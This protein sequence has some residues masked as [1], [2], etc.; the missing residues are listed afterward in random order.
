MEEPMTFYRPAHVTQRTGSRC[1]F[2]LCWAAVG[3]WLA[4]AASGGATTVTPEDFARKAGG[5]SG[6]PNATTGCKTGFEV[7]LQKGLSNLG[8]DSD[9]LTIPYA[10][11]LERMAPERRHVFAVAVDY[12]LW[13]PEQD[14]MNGTAGPDVDHMVGIIPGKD[15]RGRVEAMNPLCGDYQKVSL[16]A[17]STAARKFGRERSREGIVVVRVARPKVGGLPADKARIADLED[18]VQRQADYIEA[19]ITLFQ[20]GIEIPVPR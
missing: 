5:G 18:L 1:Q 7:D 12:S 11:F 19:T 6:K 4:S 20:R 15:T 16:A 17:I 10:S 13:P 2:S 8:L 3:S 14:C 9:I